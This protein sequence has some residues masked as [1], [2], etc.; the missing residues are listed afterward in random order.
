MRH[1]QVTQV[2]FC[3]ACP[4]SA[5][6]SSQ[7]W[8]CPKHLNPET[9]RRYP[10]HL[11]Q[12]QQFCP[13]SK[14]EHRHALQRVYPQS[15]SF[16]QYPQFIATDTQFDSFDFTTITKTIFVPLETLCQCIKVTC[17]YIWE[18]LPVFETFTFLLQTS[19]KIVVNKN[20]VNGR[21]L[22]K[23]TPFLTLRFFAGL[24]V[25]SLSSWKDLVKVT[26]RSLPPLKTENVYS[27]NY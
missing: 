17:T 7:S 9:Y 2:I 5:S 26:E 25:Y 4:Y 3:P 11:N 6:H 10:N 14:G 18:S 1:P 27:S 21:F 19:N 23:A 8:T 15:Y 12:L 20:L 24:I 22:K 16:H 13:I